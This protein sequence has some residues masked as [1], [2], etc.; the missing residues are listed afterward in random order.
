MGNICKT[1]A[2]ENDI[3]HPIMWHTYSIR[4]PNFL[5]VDYKIFEDPECN[6]S[7]TEFITRRKSEVNH[8]LGL[9]MVRSVCIKFYGTVLHINKFSKHNV[10]GE[11]KAS[12]L[13]YGL[14]SGREY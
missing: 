11:F 2:K 13:S 6:K 5:F 1:D 4:E 7:Y 12:M 14:I 3:C 9:Q 8:L 10:Y